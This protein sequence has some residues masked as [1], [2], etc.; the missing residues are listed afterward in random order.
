MVW[1][2][3]ADIRKD[4]VLEELY[5]II[6]KDL[7][8]VVE[9][10]IEKVKRV[11]RCIKARVF[12]DWADYIEF[13]VDGGLV[14]GLPSTRSFYIHK[15]NVHEDVLAIEVLRDTMSY[16]LARIHLW[17]IRYSETCY[18][19]VNILLLSI[20]DLAQAIIY[21]M[22]VEMEKDGEA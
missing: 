22:K 6:R 12:T 2:M 8:E 18:M 15:S 19:D 21:D 3:S 7:E 11:F 16:T 5:D 20:N 4:P 10:E 13:T 14:A 17:F 1:G 9:Y